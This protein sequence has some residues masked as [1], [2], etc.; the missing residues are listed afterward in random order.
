MPTRG[1]NEAREEGERHCW[2]TERERAVTRGRGG[3]DV[4]TLTTFGRGPRTGDGG[5]ALC[6]SPEFPGRM[7][8]GCP[9]PRTRVPRRRILS[10]SSSPLPPEI[11]ARRRPSHSIYSHADPRY[12]HDSP[13]VLPVLPLRLVR[14]PRLGARPPWS[15]RLPRGRRARGTAPHGPQPGRLRGRPPVVVVRGG[16]GGG[17][18]VRGGTASRAS[19]P[20]GG[21]E[22]HQRAGGEGEEVAGGG[23]AG[24][25]RGRGAPP[26]SSNSHF[27]CCI[28]ASLSNAKM[29]ISKPSS[30]SVFDYTG[31]RRI[32]T[33]R[34]STP[35]STARRPLLIMP[36]PRLLPP[37]TARRR[38]RRRSSRR[39]GR[40]GGG[41]VGPAREGSSSSRGRQ[42]GGRRRR[43]SQQWRPRQCRPRPRSPTRK[44]PAGPP[45]ARRGPPGATWREWR[46][47]S[48]GT[49]TS[50]S[51]GGRTGR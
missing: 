16:T 7:L 9:A 8:A 26:V 34:T 51:S 11:P 2:K 45:A 30:L 5:K 29:L 17:A 47:S 13:R 40:G 35:P 25:V 10:P 33:T 44:K 6:P 23:R 15:R 20:E 32:P 1:G 37:T 14:L 28:T 12:L 18:A 36:R 43:H 41:S 19:V 50:S 27:E 31:R 22:E 39:S 42:R 3:T 38:P 24:L 49:G 48:R 4:K 21:E 46:R